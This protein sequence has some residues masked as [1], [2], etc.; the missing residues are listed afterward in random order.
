MHDALE[1]TFCE[2]VQRVVVDAV[3]D[4]RVGAL[5]RRR[6]QHLRR[7]GVEVDGRLVAVAED[8]GALEHDVDAE[9][10][11]RQL[12]RIALRQ[13]LD[14][15]AVDG[16]ALVVGAD[17]AGERAVHRVVLEQMRVRL[18]VA[19]VVDRDELDVVAAFL[20]RRAQNQAPDAPETVDANP[21]RHS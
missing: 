8:A 16:D 17:L 10:L 11:P 7:A 2:F 14:L 1:T 20:H 3:D 13:H 6:D 4:G 21:N 9:V 5:R 19:E 18:D 15:V 12:G